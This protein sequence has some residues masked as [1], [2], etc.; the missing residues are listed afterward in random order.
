[1]GYCTLSPQARG[2]LPPG[3][4]EKWPFFLPEPSEVENFVSCLDGSGVNLFAVVWPGYYQGNL[5]VL[6]QTK[7][8]PA[9]G[10]GSQTFHLRWFLER[11]SVFPG[12]FPCIWNSCTAGGPGPRLT[13]FGPVP[14]LGLNWTTC[15]SLKALC[16]LSTRRAP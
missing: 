14:S 10:P 7:Q 16:L 11:P 3:F 15:P 2:L 12:G 4:L 8:A 5:R 6:L 1:M 13:D 9:V